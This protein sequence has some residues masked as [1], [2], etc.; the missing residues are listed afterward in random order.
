MKKAVKYVY[1]F[2]PFYIHLRNHFCPKC[3][4]KMEL[5]NE[6][7]TVDLRSK[8]AKNFDFSIGDSFFL[9]EVEFRKKYFYCPSCMIEFSPKEVREIERNNK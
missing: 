3:G 4:K 7:K 6:C 1:D 8:E 2:N 9:G 5:R